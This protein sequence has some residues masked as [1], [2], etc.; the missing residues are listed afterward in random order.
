MCSRRERFSS[1]SA[2]R[3][4][5]AAVTR[6]GPIQKG[7]AAGRNKLR[8]GRPSRKCI[9]EQ[10]AGAVACSSLTGLTRPHSG[11]LDSTN[12]ATRTD[13]VTALV[14]S[15]NLHSLMSLGTRH[16]ECKGQGLASAAVCAPVYQ[17][18]LTDRG[19]SQSGTAEG[20]HCCL[21]PGHA[22]HG[23]PGAGACLS[24]RR[25][26]WDADRVCGVRQIDPLP[27]PLRLAKAGFASSSRAESQAARRQ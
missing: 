6:S 2:C 27:P 14:S 25:L 4:G 24:S 5:T 12:A 26:L 13:T 16:A 18:S 3:L 8:P 19:T 9:V 15:G 1:T 21:N 11:G 7:A 20:M 10:D 22:E 23:Q 17:G